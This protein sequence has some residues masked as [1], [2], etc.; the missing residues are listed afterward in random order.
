M[1][2]SRAFPTPGVQPSAVRMVNKNLEATPGIEPGYAV[3]QTAASPLRH[4]AIKGTSIND[5]SGLGNLISFFA[6]VIPKFC[7]VLFRRSTNQQMRPSLPG[8]GQGALECPFCIPLI[9]F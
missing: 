5:H 2:E 6:A 1:P 7:V 9:G 8:G 4:V 3:L